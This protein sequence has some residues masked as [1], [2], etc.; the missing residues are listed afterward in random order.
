MTIM[1]AMT[2]NI[3]YATAPALQTTG[4]QS[5]KTEINIKKNYKQKEAKS[6]PV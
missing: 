3:N 2:I 4:K 1:M 6:T 5:T